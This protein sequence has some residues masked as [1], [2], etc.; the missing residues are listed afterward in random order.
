MIEIKNLCKTYDKFVALNNLNLSIQEKEFFGFVGPNGAGKTTTMRILSGLLKADSGEVYIDG[1]DA[2]KDAQSLKRKIGYV[3]D[4]FGVYDNFKV[5]EYMEF[6][7]SVYGIKGAAAQKLCMELLELVHLEDKSE[8]YVDGLSRGMKQRLC[9]ARSLVHNPD[10][11]ILDEPAS[12]LDPGARYDIKSILK[13]LN[14]RGKT[15]IISSHILSEL[16]KM[17]TTIGVIDQ[18]SMVVKGTVDEIMQHLEMSNPIEIE[19]L[20]GTEQAVHILKEYPRVK[21]ISIQG[22]NITIG[23]CGK[24]E[25]EAEMLAILVNHG[26]KVASYVRQSG[27]LEEVFMKVTKRGITD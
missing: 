5:I 11:L 16:D 26:I 8:F 12:G 22:N 15:I 2:L 21:S 14:E 23:F 4:F 3:P 27:N 20:N 13:E 18:G 9:L 1:T 17:C 25:D 7:A 10:L 6:Y 19:I 24:K